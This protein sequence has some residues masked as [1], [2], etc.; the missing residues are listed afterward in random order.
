[1]GVSSRPSGMSKKQRS[2]TIYFAGALFTTKDLI[3]N[4][5]LAEAIYECSHGRYRCLLPQDFSLRGRS[6]HAI[7]DHALRTLFA[8]DLAL[9]N[10]DGL[11]LD[12]GT[13]VEFTA[14]K[15][16]DI[17]AVLLRS[18]ARSAAPRRPP[19]WNAMTSFFPRTATVLLPSLPLYRSWQEKRHPRAADDVVRLAGQHSSADAQRVC[20]QVALQ[21]VRAFDRLVALAPA[22]PKHLR[23]EVYQW[24]AL[25]PGLRGKSKMLRKELERALEQKVKRELL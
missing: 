7:R 3:G 13:V 21:C 20:E 15:F 14:A 25:M 10:Y 6:P 8:A 19:P 22:M 4:A 9:F 1:M 16:A 5:Y 18:D 24:L 11:E 2:Y 12:S 17:P 23:E